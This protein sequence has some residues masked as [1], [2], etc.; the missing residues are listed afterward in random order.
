MAAFVKIM[1][2]RKAIL[3]IGKMVRKLV[4]KFTSDDRR[5]DG[6]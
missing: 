5:N 1:N 4:K 2:V 6:L 3:E